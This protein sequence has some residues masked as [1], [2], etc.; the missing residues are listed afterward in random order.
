MKKHLL[1]ALA[2]VCLAV[3]LCLGAT[4]SEAVYEI[5]PS[6][7]NQVFQGG[8]D[9]V[10][11]YNEDHMV[12]V[13]KNGP[14]ET[15]KSNG[16]VYGTSKPEV[17]FDG[18]K[19]QWIK[20]R[21]RNRSA[22][23]VFEFHFV[24]D[25]T[26]GKLVADSCTHFPIT[27]ND[28]EFKEYIFNIPECNMSSQ[29]VNADVKLEKSVWSGK[30]S[31]LRYDFMWIAEPSG[32]V[33][34]GSE[35]DVQYIGFFESEEAAK[36]HTFVS[37]ADQPNDGDWD[38]TYAWVYNTAA[39]N[40]FAM[41]G[42]D[43]AVE[44]GA[45]KVLPT[46]SDPMMT[47]NFPEGEGPD[48]SD[49]RYVA[50]RMSSVSEVSNGALFVGTTNKPTLSGEGHNSFALTNN[51][52]WQRIILDMQTY[53]KY[54]AEGG[55]LTILRL[56]PINGNDTNAVIY[57]ERLGIFK[58]VID[59]NNFL[60]EEIDKYGE[61]H[62]YGE[63]HRAIVPSGVLSDGFDKA[64]YM[65][66]ADEVLKSEDGKLPVVYFTDA[67]GN[68]SVVPLC[69][70]NPVGYT[71]YIAKKAGTYTVAFNNKEYSD[72]AG[73][74][75]EGYIDFVSERALFGGT[76][77]TEFS[78][79][80]TMTRGMFV[81][82]LGRMH[83]VDTSA[84]DGNTGY[85]DVP[86]TE[87][88]A[89]YIQWAKEIGI[90]APV[91]ETEFAP[92]SPI[93]REVMAVVI[94]NYV[95]AFDYKF[96]SNAEPIVFNDI[97]SLSADS[98]AAIEAAQKAGI[99]NGK[100]NGIFDPAGIS[101]RAEVATVM[102]RVI[103]GI[104]GIPTYNNPYGEGYHTRDRIRVGIWN[105]NANKFNSDEA[106]K[107]AADLGVDYVVNAPSTSV[108]YIRE[109]FLN[110]ADKYGMEVNL[111]LVGNLYNDPNA[112][113]DVFNDASDY[114]PLEMTSD[115][116]E[117]PSFGG[118][119]IIDEPGMVDYERFA[120][121][122]NEYTEML[123]DKRPF[124]NLLPMYASDAQ[125]QYGANVQ[126]IQYYDNTGD[127]YK[128]YCDS[129][130]ATHNVD[131][132]CTDIY[133]LSWA[134]GIKTTY[135]DYV[136]SINIIATSAREFGREFFCCIQTFDWTSS[137]SKRDPSEEEFRW[138]TYAMLSFG[139]TGILLWTYWS[140]ND[141]SPAVVYNDGTPT[142][143]YDA[144]KPV[145]WEIRRLSDTFIKYK[146]VGAFTHNCTEATPYLKMSGEYENFDIISNIDCKDPLLVGCF[147]SKETDGYA[148]TLV[149]MIE[150]QNM[151]S[152]TVNFTLSDTTKTV[153]VYDNDEPQ[154]ITAV[155]G[156][157][158]VVLGDGQ[159]V[160]V[161]VE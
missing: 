114:N 132:I 138:Q 121:I 96:V 134:S 1:T 78:P 47:I 101:T 160:F 50:I 92:E 68:S 25:G 73:H 20:L 131:Y 38:K 136:E 33:P 115:Y 44:F 129:F 120:E 56:D 28:T 35:M 83:G 99:I 71:R 149:N 42:I 103:K 109:S 2:V 16:D 41:A 142:Y 36:A 154:V 81:T 27:A 91:S 102:Q 125:L 57:V 133:P 62:F 7:F 66:S 107:L 5:M 87:Y 46:N 11:I 161:T 93:T 69:Y 157:Y 17:P 39:S 32:Q 152:T 104:L 8:N 18:D 59:A 80:D 10:F 6:V 94:A 144:A 55:M 148:F 84:Y 49:Y 61:T 40:N 70:T 53:N 113:D 34:T 110:L 112:E 74:W 159:G 128:R 158:T 82:V 58:N 65:L 43:S 156:V 111:D 100:G 86:A 135:K 14:G 75:G 26:G 22:A 141:D 15:E 23:E 139:C 123:P 130:N 147:E 45:I 37:D 146:N 30:I 19:Y 155:N 106:F 143:N 13:S 76:S 3:I 51:G 122:C 64:Q 153:T 4:A 63:T 88:Y 9:C 119:Y 60:S 118:H 117:H 24:S 54:W 150:W 21:I 151:T 77:P 31:T 67:S 137:N 140:G 108:P 105:F 127:I 12:V 72:I 97:T 126:S 124:I 29:N 89:P 98:V 95:K 145:M 79:E 52:E 48:T 116:Y 90:F 85:A